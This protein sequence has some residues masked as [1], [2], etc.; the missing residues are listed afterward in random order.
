[1]VT[2]KADPSVRTH[3]RL[4]GAL[5]RRFFAAG[6]VSD[7]TIDCSVAEP[8]VAAF[9]R[10]ISDGLVVTAL[11]DRATDEPLPFEM[12]VTIGIAHTALDR[13]WPALT[14]EPPEDVIFHGLTGFQ[15]GI[16]VRGEQDVATAAETLTDIL[17]GRV[18]S[19]VREYGSVDAVLAANRGPDVDLDTEMYVVPALLAVAGRFEDARAALVAYQ[20]SRVR[21][22][23]DRVLDPDRDYRR[24]TERLT[25]WLDSGGD[26]E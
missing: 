7:E 6:W 14:G 3:L 8:N 19:Y 21:A 5:E 18:D 4:Q 12:G 24:F 11:F 16:T 22:L 20:P 1:M 9:R 15:E 26:A 10:P 23:F 2:G 25:W 13:L 17:M